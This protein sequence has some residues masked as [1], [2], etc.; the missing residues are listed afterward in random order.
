MADKQQIIQ[1]KQQELQNL[2][3]RFYGLQADLKEHKR[4]LE[5][6]ESLEDSRISYR[7]I[8]DVLAKQT[9]GEVK[10]ILAEMIGQ[11]QN[12]LE[13]LEKMIDAKAKDFKT[14]QA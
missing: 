10:P 14:L 6:L 9:V 7:L 13:Q 3:Q 2:S 12:V 4:V 5:Q 11:L 8:G 1:Q